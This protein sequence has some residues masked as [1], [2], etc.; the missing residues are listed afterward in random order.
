MEPT[1]AKIELTRAVTAYTKPAI[2]TKLVFSE[3]SAIPVALRPKTP[4]KIR[5]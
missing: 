1:N 5:I 2:G 4:N 3:F